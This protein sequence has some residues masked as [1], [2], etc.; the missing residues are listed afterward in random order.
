MSSLPKR[1][2]MD[3]KLVEFF[4]NRVVERR[5]MINIYLRGRA[6]IESVRRSADFEFVLLFSW[7][8]HFSCLLLVLWLLLLLDDP[9]KLFVGFWSSS[10][11]S[12]GLGFE[13]Q[14]FYFLSMDSSRGRLIN[15]I[16]SSLI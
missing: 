12:W 15:Q 4:A 2:S 5:N 9:L 6:C 14:T 3:T 11:A 7:F 10:C 13:I 16:V 8:C 1:E